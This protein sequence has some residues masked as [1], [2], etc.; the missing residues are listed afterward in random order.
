[1]RDFARR[2]SPRWDWLRRDRTALNKLTP[3][4]ILVLD[5]ELRFSLRDEQIIPRADW[6]SCLIIAGRGWGKT[7]ACVSEV[8]RQVRAKTAR[9]IGLMGP[10]DERTKQEMVDRII[11]LSPVWDRPEYRNNELHWPNGAKAQCF[12]AENPRGPRG[13][14]FDLVWCSELV[15][16]PSSTRIDAWDAI[17]TA[18]RER[19]FNRIL[20]DSTSLGKNDLI[21]KR[22]EACEQDP[23]RHLY[24]RGDSFDN[25]LLGIEYLKDEWR[26][27]G[28]GRRREEELLGK[29]FTEAAG[30]LWEQ[31]WI[32]RSR[33]HVTPPNYSIRL[34][35]VDPTTTHGRDSDLM[36]MIVG[37][38]TD[39]EIYIVKDLSGKYD[40]EK[41]ADRA[42]AEC[43]AGA[44]GVICE[45]TGNSGGHYLLPIIRYA[46]L[47]KGLEVEDWTGKEGPIPPK[48]PGKVFWRE[49]KAKDAKETRAY[50]PAGMTE[51][52]Q[53]HMVGHHDSLE[54]E[55][56]TWVPGDR[57]S[58]NRLDAFAY[59]VLELSGLQRP[60]KQSGSQQVAGMVAAH[61]RMKQLTRVARSRRTI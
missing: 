19:E 31:E 23:L 32:D 34:V 52:G 59:L 56:T 5:E 60:T 6:I 44:S 40:G 35:S 7:H 21:I 18:T 2:V 30:A 48:R 9:K 3:A 50:A 53:V 61:E 43:L 24:I 27:Y 39:G 51:S 57:K 4:E 49:I 25:P 47:Q 29:V 36:G 14:N 8:N 10:T 54:Y 45:G 1:M 46:A 33:R 16:W 17:T 20:A 13:S 41:W 58:P 37:Q 15:A 42:I 38:E 55:M 12:T 28:P 11:A 22:I 26:K